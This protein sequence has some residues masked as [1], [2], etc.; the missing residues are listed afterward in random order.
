MSIERR[1]LGKTGLAV[2]VL[3]FGGSEI[4]YQGVPL[5]T[6][7]KVLNG[8][9]DEGLNVI[10]TAECYADSEELVGKALSSRRG[11]FVLMTKCGHSDGFL[12]RDWAPKTL[13]RTI[14]R[15]LKRL[16]TDHVDVMQFHS[17]EAETIRDDAVLSVLTRARDAGKTR[18]I[19]YSGDSGDALEAVELGVFDTLQISI[20]IADQEAIELVMPA[21]K[22]RNM[23][24]IAKRPIANAAWLTPRMSASDYSYPYRQR[25]KKLDFDFLARP[26]ESVEAALRFTLSVPGVHTAIVG[27]TKPDRWHENARYAERGALPK[28]RYDRIRARWREIAGPDWTGER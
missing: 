27:T 7:E 16:R 4:G 28:D 25:L 13:E 9:L 20:S 15:S 22:I 24:V 1:V 18:F 21:A 12:G 19:G 26:S 11:E 23:G 17:P 14:E 8:A 3:G 5:R 2:S 10:D 6:V